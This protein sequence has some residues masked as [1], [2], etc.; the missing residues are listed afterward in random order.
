M[1]YLQ[2]PDTDE[3]LGKAAQGDAAA[4]DRLF[5]R[6][7]GRLRQMVAVRMDGRLSARIDPSDV[8][9]EALATASRQLSEYLRAPPLPFYLWLRRIAWNRLVDLYRRHV[10]RASRSVARE[11]PLG[12]S[13]DSAFQLADQLLATGLEPVHKLIQQELRARVRATLAKLGQLDQEILV[14][15][16]LELLSTRECAAALEISEAAAK[17]R[18]VRALARLRRLLDDELSEHTG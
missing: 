5:A 18:Y 12:L 3:L 9:Q 17:K 16:H 2:E 10:V 4:V 11:E 14:L 7:R 6:H 1:T 13:N 8:V 15:R